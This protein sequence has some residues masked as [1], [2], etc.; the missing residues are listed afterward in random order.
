MTY[1]SPATAYDIARAF[2]LADAK[3]IIAVLENDAPEFLHWGHVGTVNKIA[4][5]LAEVR[6]FARAYS[7]SDRRTP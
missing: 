2:A 5:D 6:R 7:P 1:A 3:A 4:A